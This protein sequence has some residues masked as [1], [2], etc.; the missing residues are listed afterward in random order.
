MGE[1]VSEI[2]NDVAAGAGIEG[3]S[4][5]IPLPEQEPKVLPRSGLG[6]PTRSGHV[7]IVDD[8]ATI[9]LMLA[10]H[11]RELGHQVTLSGDGRD[12]LKL[13]GEQS[14]DLVLLDMM[15]PGMDGYAVLKQIKEDPG[16]REIPVVMISGVD[17]IKL[18]TRCIEIG[19]EDYLPKP[20]EPALLRARVRACLDKKQMWDE[21]ETRYRQLKDLEQLRDSLTYMIVHDLRTPLTSLLTGL[22]TLEAIGDLDAIQ[23]EMLEVSVSGGNTL[24]GMINDLLDVSKMEDGSLALERGE[25][26]PNALIWGALQQV[27]ALAQSKHLHLHQEIAPDLPSLWADEEKLR[28]VL[29]NLVSNAIKFTPDSGD[30]TVSVRLQEQIQEQNATS[31]DNSTQAASADA[32]HGNALLFMVQ[33]TGEG[34]PRESFGRIF[35]KFGQVENRKAGRKMSTGLGL[36]FCK[37]VVEAHGGKIRVESELGQGSTFLFTIPLEDN[38]PLKTLS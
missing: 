32:Q 24:L 35:E 25:V 33:D 26:A 31:N 38:I 21:L 17:D 6:M 3:A 34:I 22:Q 9:R 37:M 15:M 4:V 23:T 7:L 30:I 18:V 29:V 1:S 2:I 12:A 14:F 5:P 10:R 16:L 36:T 28:R 8:L 27:K 19:A 20:F 13:L 11:V